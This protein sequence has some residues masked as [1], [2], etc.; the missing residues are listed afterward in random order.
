MKELR[1]TVT[2]RRIH[3]MWLWA[4]WLATSSAYRVC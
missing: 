1:A 3:A 4:M 2:L